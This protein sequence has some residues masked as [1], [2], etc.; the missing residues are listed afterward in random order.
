MPLD[1][2]LHKNRKEYLEEKTPDGG[3]AMPWSAGYYSPRENVSRFYVP[4]SGDGEGP[5]PLDLLK[6]LAHELTHHWLSMRWLGPGSRGG[7]AVLPGYWIV[8]GFA[9]FMEDQAMEMGRRQGRLEVRCLRFEES[10]SPRE[11]GLSQDSLK[12]YA[13]A[14]ELSLDPS[15]VPA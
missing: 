13:E 2:R 6:T 9:R 10:A 11:R 4:G 7:A 8:E 12:R 14:L 1:G 3:Q 5:V 15:T